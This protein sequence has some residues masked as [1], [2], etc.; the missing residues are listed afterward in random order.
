MKINV[1]RVRARG[2][3]QYNVPEFPDLVGYTNFKDKVKKAVWIVEYGDI[4]KVEQ[5][6]RIHSGIE[7]IPIIN[8]IINMEFDRKYRVYLNERC[9][10][11]V[12]RI[13]ITKKWEFIINQKKYYIEE[14][15]TNFLRPFKKYEWPVISED[16]TV[17]LKVSTKHRTGRY[18]VD[19]IKDELDITII[20]IM[21]MMTDIYLFSE[22]VGEPAI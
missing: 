16:G 14:G 20:V 10:G 12:D 7:H 11:T 1:E 3:Y 15:N 2:N 6:N 8:T 18:L 13:G 17:L 19:I 22:E 9:I 5:V 4:C 21:V